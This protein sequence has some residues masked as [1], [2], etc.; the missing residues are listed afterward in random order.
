[1]LREMFRVLRPGGYLLLSAPFRVDL[2]QTLV[3]ASV[4]PDGT[5]AHHEA[6]EYHGN[7]IDPEGA[8]C[9]FTTSAGICSIPCGV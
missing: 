4:R 2:T 7:P 6:P 9:A 8:A 1:M 5:I 3:R